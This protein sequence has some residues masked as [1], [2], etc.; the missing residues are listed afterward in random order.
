MSASRILSSA[1]RRPALLAVTLGLITLVIGVQT[2]G[3]QSEAAG[4]VWVA[5][6]R[7]SRQPDPSSQPTAEAIRHGRML[8]QRECDLCHGRSGH[9]DGTQASALHTKPANLASERVRSQSDG[10]LFYKITEGR[11]EMPKAKLS[12]AEKWNVIEYIRTL[13]P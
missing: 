7:A 4:G 9:G 1:A 3:A 12:D 2:A 6:E 10:A 11:G 5:P 8:F 13:P